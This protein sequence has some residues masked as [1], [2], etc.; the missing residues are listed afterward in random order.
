MSKKDL[1]IAFV[2]LAAGES[3]RMGKPKQLILWK[4]EM[5]IKHIVRIAKTSCAKDVFVVLGAHSNL[6]IPYLD[7]DVKVLINYNWK[8]GLAS[9]IVCAMKYF[10]KLDNKYDGIIFSLVDQPL[11][12]EYHYSSLINTFKSCDYSIV[13]TEYDDF[14][15]VPAIFSSKLFSELN[16]LKGNQG[17]KKII[18]QNITNTF[19]LKSNNQLIDID[20]PE[21]FKKLLDTY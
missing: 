17:A 6:I 9:S 8:K 5:L 11:I 18:R 12:E 21:D 13:A 4:G 15:G 10:S 20:T 2:I 1:N 19:L 7:E 3:K 16:Q 14:A